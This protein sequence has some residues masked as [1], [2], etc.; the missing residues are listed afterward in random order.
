MKH[1]A[2]LEKS[3][4][5]TCCLATSLLPSTAVAVRAP[6]RWRCL[7]I[8]RVRPL[9]TL[10]AIPV[11]STRP[12]PTRILRSPSTWP[13]ADNTCKV[14]I[15]RQFQ[16]PMT[17]LDLALTQHV[18]SCWQHLS[19][20]ITYDP[21]AADNVCKVSEQLSVSTTLDQAAADNTCKVSATSV[22]LNHPW[23]T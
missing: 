1:T 7:E 8:C 15:T 22:S 21:P 10:T 13:A 11:S 4:A 12:R 5:L 19:V 2:K 16:T 14:R 18:A 20:S 17:H 23:P 9:T 3:W 6:G